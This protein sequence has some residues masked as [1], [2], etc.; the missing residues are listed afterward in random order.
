MY[1]GNGSVVDG[2]WPWYGAELGVDW[3][4]RGVG[5]VGRLEFGEP[6]FGFWRGGW[7]SFAKTW[8]RW[9]AMIRPDWIGIF[10]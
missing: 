2:V 1:G 6:G 8:K 9:D 5:G 3:T 7:I 10:G 4:R